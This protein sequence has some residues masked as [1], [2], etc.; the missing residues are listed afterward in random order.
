MFR[1][2]LVKNKKH[3][4]KWAKREGVTCF[5]L[6]DADL[7][8]WA[9]AVDLYEGAAHVQ[10]YAPPKTVD[11]RKAAERLEEAMR[12]VPEV[13]ELP[14]DAVFLKVRR[15][16]RPET[17]YERVSDSRARREV[18]EG[19]CRFIVNLSD[20]VDTGLYLDHRTLRRMVGELAKGRRF[21][22]LFAYTGTATVHA[23]LGGARDTTSVDISNTYLDW[24]DEN[25]ALN[26]MLPAKHHLVRE[27]V[28]VWLPRQRDRFGLILLTPPTFSNSKRMSQPLDAQ[29]DHAALIRAAA[30]RL[31]PDGVLLFSVHAQRFKL[32]EAALTGLHVEEITHKTVPPDFART[33]RIHRAWRVTR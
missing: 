16:Q 19:D 6:Y 10:E 30:D 12:V 28:L 15:R 3:L 14:A 2:R 26:R 11:A 5:R 29:R 22:N 9:V 8:E 4:A 33:P 32:D 17:Q 31:E 25:F 21:L 20:Y 18:H 23:A 27:D 13:L 7:P 24:A 1:N